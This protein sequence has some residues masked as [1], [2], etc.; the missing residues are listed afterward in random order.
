MSVSI[1]FVVTHAAGVPVI[2]YC[3]D[4]QALTAINVTP[5]E[6]RQPIFFKRSFGLLISGLAIFVRLGHECGSCVRFSLM[7]ETH[8]RCV[9]VGKHAVL[10]LNQRQVK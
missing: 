1:V 7:R 8:A 2:V 9:K 10:K 3:T 4:W 6:F 5:K